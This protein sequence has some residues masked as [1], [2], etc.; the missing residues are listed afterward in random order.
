MWIKG[1]KCGEWL[2]ESRKRFVDKMAGGEETIS[3]LF[4]EKEG[5][6]TVNVLFRLKK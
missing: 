6:A 5:V 2:N 1:T 4:M 3:C